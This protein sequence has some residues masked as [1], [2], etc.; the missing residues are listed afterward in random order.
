MS[1]QRLAEILARVEAAAPGP[2][3]SDGAE[4]YGTLAGVL[5]I[6]LW[7]GETLDIDD[8]PQSEANAAFVAAAR[9]DVPELVA[10]VQRLRLL[11]GA[12]PV[13]LSEDQ[14]GALIDA[15][16]GALSDYYHE[17]QCACSEYPAGCVT[18][19]AYRREFG[20]WDTDA[21]ALGMGAVL[22]VWES[23]RENSAAVELVALK[24]RIAELEA[25]RGKA[26]A[27]RDEQIIAWLA[28]KAS[29]YRGNRTESASDA[30]ARMADK[31]HRGAVRPAM[32]PIAR[33]QEDPHDGPL[34][35]RYTTP[36]DLDTPGSA[37]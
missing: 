9:T 20:Y 19:L 29:E 22:G 1:E 24:A 8:L 2:W 4:F 3:E 6:D 30:L 28:K 11:L 33:Q 16:N 12:S 36:H 14:L 37:L 32:P 5:M 27:D 17:R 31:L 35:T 21:F 18:N 23:I 25:E 26:A 13:E 15:G 34:A 10:E 7:V